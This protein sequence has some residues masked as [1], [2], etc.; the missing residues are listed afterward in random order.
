MARK[1]VTLCTLCALSL[2]LF[3][4]YSAFCMPGCWF[5]R[6][7]LS[8][9][10]LSVQVNY[11]RTIGEPFV[12]IVISCSLLEICEHMKV[13]VDPAPSEHNQR[14]GTAKLVRHLGHCVALDDGE[15]CSDTLRSG[16]IRPN[17]VESAPCAKF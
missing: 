4:L 7:S 9:C 12:A 3:K 6:K 17:S 10:R 1:A 8:L 14:A 16:T 2:A 15:L 11:W 13:Q 5:L